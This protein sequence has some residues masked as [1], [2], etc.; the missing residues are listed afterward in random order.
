M[1]CFSRWFYFEINY[2][3]CFCDYKLRPVSISFF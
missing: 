2:S 1:R 3:L